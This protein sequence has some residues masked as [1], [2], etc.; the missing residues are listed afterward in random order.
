MFA[1]M[2][3]NSLLDRSS[4]GG[5]KVAATGFKGLDGVHPAAF[6]APAGQLIIA[7]A[8][9]QL[10]VAGWR[11][12]VVAPSAQ[13]VGNGALEICGWGAVS[14]WLNKGSA[15]GFAWSLCRSRTQP[16]PPTLGSVYRR[17]LTATG[18]NARAKPFC[19]RMLSVCL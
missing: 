16:L 19:A 2:A 12:R 3:S 9:G 8:G 13:Q 15:R 4:T 6:C 1:Y 10:L 5:A 18:T 17:K 7:V 11:S 14:V